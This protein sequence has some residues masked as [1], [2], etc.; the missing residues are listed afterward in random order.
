MEEEFT[1]ITIQVGNSYDSGIS[2]EHDDAGINSFVEYQYAKKFPEV[3]EM[4]DTPDT[5]L[6]ST[7]T[8]SGAAIQRIS[9]EIIKVNVLCDN[10]NN[11]WDSLCVIKGKLDPEDQV[12]S[13]H[14]LREISLN[15][16][17][18]MSQCIFSDIA[19]KVVMFT[20][21]MIGE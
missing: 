9:R 8:K 2:V 13:L 16:L 18:R 3:L 19:M 12:V 21:K 20:G 15:I 11:I 17:R 14:R 10:K 6:F 7:G 4:R 5:L 1:R